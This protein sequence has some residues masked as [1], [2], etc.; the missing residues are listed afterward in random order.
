MN[1]I[2]IDFIDFFKL[3]FPKIDEKKLIKI[4]F[5][6][7]ARNEKYWDIWFSR[8]ESQNFW[9][10]EFTLSK[11]INF[12]VE[13]EILIKKGKKL[14]KERDFYCNIYILSDSFIQLFND[15]KFFGQKVFEYID[16]IVWMNRFVNFIEKRKKFNFEVKWKK[17]FIPKT[18]R[19]K[20]KIYS[21]DDNKIISPSTLI[22]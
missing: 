7:K 5:T 18:W 12:L 6:L 4:I 19:F 15:L 8:L 10:S 14:R 22:T 20:G 21:I 2:L 13:N 16:P 11:I 9:L 17:Y 1:K 3:Q